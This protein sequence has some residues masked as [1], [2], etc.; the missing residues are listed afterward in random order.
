MLLTAFSRL[1]W[2]SAALA[3][4]GSGMAAGPDFVYRNPITEGLDPRGLRDCQVFRDDGKWYLTGTAFPVWPREDTFGQLNPGVVLYSSED[5]THWTFA[6]V[7]V[8]PNAEKWNFQRFWAPEVH[9]FGGK[10]YATFNCRN[11]QLGDNLMRVGY[12]VADR[13]AGPYRVMD[14]PLA[15]GND[16]HL[17]QDDD[18]KVWAFWNGTM[19]PGGDKAK[20]RAFGVSYAQVDLAGGRL[21]TEPVRAIAYGT[22]G[23]DWDGVGIE[24]SYVIK[25]NGI[26]YLFFSSWTRGYEIGY[27]TAPSVTGPW[28]KYPGNPIYG[29]QDPAAC[30]KNGVPYLGDPRSDFSQVGHNAIFT[31]PD[32]RLWLSCHGIL[33]ADPRHI[34]MLVIEPLDFDSTGIVHVAAPSRDIRRITLS[35]D[36]P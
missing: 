30:A 3:V 12:A 34:P 31:G 14:Q 27:A 36:T 22:E 11:P 1:V 24:G 19:E 35:K 13:L 4:S 8:R 7:L 18:G 9:P 25:R 6:Q 33:R 21:L 26:Y 5:L 23:Q 28:T 29:A 17:F 10:Y 16:L 20:V 32:G 15:L 2:F